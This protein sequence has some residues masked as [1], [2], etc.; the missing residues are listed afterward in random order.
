VKILQSDDG[1][2]FA[3]NALA[4][5]LTGK[6][7]IGK[8]SLP[9][10][11]YQNGVIKRF[12][13]TVAEMGRT[14]LSNSRLPQSFWGLAFLWAMHVLN[15]IPNKASGEK[16][17]FEAL[18][19]RP[20]CFDGFC[21]FGSKAYIHVPKG[22]RKKLDDRAY[23]GIV[24]GHLEESKG[25]LFYIPVADEFVESSM[26]RCV[27]S[28]SPFQPPAPGNPNVTKTSPP[29]QIPQKQLLP[30]KKV[31]VIDTPIKGATPSPHP[32][33]PPPPPED[34][35]CMRPVLACVPPTKMS[36]GF[37]AN[38]VALGDF[39]VEEEFVNQELIID[40]FLETC[41]FYDVD[42]P[43]TFKQAMKSNHVTEWKAAISEEMS[44]LSKMEVWEARP[45]PAG[46]S[47]LDVSF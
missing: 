27:D 40:T 21:V 44:N 5:F 45:L 12:N 39:G 38:H 41:S 26:A 43:N 11:H 14:V 17:P 18:F 16:T 8:H 28:L 6:G 7:I 33:L 30:C 29:Y 24:V 2:E 13:Q 15:C 22:K 3:N 19:L 1:G 47:V 35:S 42:I 20:P 25:W 10:H 37:I 23:K 9:Y 32:L 36:L 46:Q 31:T 34:R 4:K